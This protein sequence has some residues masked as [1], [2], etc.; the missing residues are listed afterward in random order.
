LRLFIVFETIY[1]YE[2][3]EE[4]RELKTIS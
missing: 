4:L 3:L 2:G 1:K